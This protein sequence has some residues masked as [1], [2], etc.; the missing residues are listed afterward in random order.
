MNTIFT[1]LHAGERYAG[2]I[3]NSATGKPTHHLILL[4]H[5]PSEPLN[6]Q[7]AMEW[8]ASLTGQLPSLQEAALLYT[9]CKPAFNG[10][11]Y[12]T[13]TVHESD[14]SY[15]WGQH[16]NDGTQNNLQ[17]GYKDRVRAIRR[18]PITEN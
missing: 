7:E 1:Q 2:I 18:V 6:W 13:N 15:A 3:I 10:F 17:K 9:N 11:W 16:F 12:W 8:A 14:A 5:E 4:P